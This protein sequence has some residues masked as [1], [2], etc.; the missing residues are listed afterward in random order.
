M[1]SVRVWSSQAGLRNQKNHF[2]RLCTIPYGPYS[3]S[4][5]I[6]SHICPHF[7]ASLSRKAFSIYQSSD[8]GFRP[9]S[10]QPFSSAAHSS[11]AQLLTG[12]K[13]RRGPTHVRC[14]VLIPTTGAWNTNTT[15]GRRGR[16]WWQFPR[17]GTMKKQEATNVSTRVSNSN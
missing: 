6:F 2:P 1:D 16:G 14:P 5:L 9:E 4:S 8:N 11:L 7:P 17:M 15:G 13:P 3:F 10:M 12:P